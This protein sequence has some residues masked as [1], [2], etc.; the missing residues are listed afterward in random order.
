MKTRIIL[1]VVIALSMATTMFAGMA[2]AGTPITVAGLE[3]VTTYD[4]ASVEAWISTRPLEIVTDELGPGG[5]SGNPA[6]YMYD[7]G[8]DAT[9]WADEDVDRCALSL[10]Q[11]DRGYTGDSP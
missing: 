10:T 6:T 5:I 3:S 11:G 7:A 2:M 9:N 8:N 1:S 4:G